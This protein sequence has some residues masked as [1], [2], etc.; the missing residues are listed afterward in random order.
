MDLRMY[1]QKIRDVAGAIAGENVVVVS[2]ET[3][4]GGKAG[5]RSE[6]KRDVAARLVVDGKA[7]L[8]TAEESEQFYADAQEARARAEQAAAASKMQVTVITDHE[9]KVLR[10]R[11]RPQ[12]S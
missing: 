8:A 7:R 4:D 11:M 6:V 12:K 1:Y 3:P 10:E 5:V 2:R 9:L